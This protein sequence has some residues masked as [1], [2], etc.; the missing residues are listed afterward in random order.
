MQNMSQE[1]ANTVC[2]VCGESVDQAIQVVID[3]H[4]SEDG[5]MILRIG[6]CCDGCRAQVAAD[7]DLYFAVALRNGFAAGG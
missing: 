3:P 6:T 4:H 2:P 7:P 5:D 1:A